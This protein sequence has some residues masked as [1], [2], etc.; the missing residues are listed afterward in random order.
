[1]SPINRHERTRRD[2]GSETA[3]DYVEAIHVI[4]GLQPTCRNTDL[5]R[6]FAVSAVT[7][8]KIVRRLVQAGLVESEPYGPVTLTAAGQKLALESRKRHEAVVRFLELLGVSPE[9]AEI[10]AEGIEHH[11]SDE[12]LACFRRFISENHAKRSE[13]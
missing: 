9:A 2:H 12:T 4:L 8:S 13:G 5:A 6:H 1:M 10:D 3:E 11:V 7:S